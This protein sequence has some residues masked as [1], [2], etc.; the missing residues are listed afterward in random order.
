[1]TEAE[2]L[3]C[4]DLEAMLQFLRGKTSDRKLRLFAAESFRHLVRLLPDQRQHRAIEFLEEM[5]EGTGTMGSRGEA[6]G[7]ARRALPSQ[8]VMGSGNPTDDPHF[9][10]LM[11]YRELASSSIAVHATTAP[12]GLMKGAAEQ[13][14][15]SRLLRDVTGNP[16]RPVTLDPSWLTPTVTALTRQ[17]YESR[18]FAAMPILAD[19]LQDAGC[20][21]MD[22]LGHCRNEGAHLR[23]CWVVDLVLGKT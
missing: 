7:N 22:I 21:N 1:M 4:E 5:A 15:Q 10:A 13:E 8:A 6:M 12:A 23:G 14:W 16:F 18:D 9:V 19:A 2:W 11:L 3:A 20:D 17:M